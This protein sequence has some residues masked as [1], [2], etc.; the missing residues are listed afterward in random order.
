MKRS[1]LGVFTG[2]LLW[3]KVCHG[4][5]VLSAQDAVSYALSHRPELRAA[6]DRV[7]AS[8]RLRSQAGLIPNPRFLFRKEDFTDHPNVGE[9]SQ[10]YW[11]GEQLLETSGKRGGRIAVAQ[12]GMEQSR[13]QA[14]L[15][16]RQ[17]MLNVRE[18]YWRAKAVQSLAALY[19]QDADYFRQVVE[20]HEARFHEGK[21]AEVD[22]L[23][24]RLQGEQIRAAAASARLDSEKAL[25]MLAQEMNAAPNSFWVLSENFETLEEPKPVPPRT[26]STSLRVEGQLAQQAIAG[27]EA[28]TRLQ[29]ANGRPDLFITGGYKRD[30]DFDSPV[31][32]VQFDLPLFNR[33]QGAVA[34]AHAEEDAAR[35]DYQA[36]RNRLA[37]ELGIA[38]R[39]YEMRRE[40]YLQ[41]FKPLREQAIE[42]SNIS[43]AA[44]QAGGL[45]LLRLLDAERARVD[46]ELSYVRA[47]E[48]FHL[49]VAALNYAEGVDQ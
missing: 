17:I 5:T 8:E 2:M 20:Y 30:V 42:I 10:T 44:Y 21:I 40:Q 23:R 15:A 31:A 28:R 19:A 24:V 49:S 22:L 26:D 34:A 45:D 47:L 43:R 6:N 4:Q 7:S 46:A 11:E 27:A 1:L 33:N 12:Q 37:A 39:E 35:E 3:A 18:S 14:E 13:L 25:L 38:Q 29:K 32:G 41:T 9:N 48:G 36:T 16:Q